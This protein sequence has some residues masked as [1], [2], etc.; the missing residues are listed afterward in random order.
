MKKL[1][2]LFTMAALLFTVSA[3]AAVESMADLFGKYKFTA[4]VNVTDAGQ[5]YTEHFKS[6]CD[7]TVAK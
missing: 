2:L 7:V 3:N 4:T 5:S 1:Y 6:E